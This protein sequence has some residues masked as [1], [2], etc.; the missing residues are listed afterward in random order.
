MGLW[1]QKA[2]KV[3]WEWLD[4]WD[5]LDPRGR[6]DPQDLYSVWTMERLL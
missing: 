6:Q 3:L 5:Q 2:V 4:L 1:D